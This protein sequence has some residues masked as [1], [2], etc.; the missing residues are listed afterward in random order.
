MKLKKGDW[1][2]GTSKATYAYTNSYSV[3]EI[4]EIRT[5]EYLLV[6]CLYSLKC[7]INKE[8]QLN[9]LSVESKYFRKLTA[10]EIKKYY[11]LIVAQQI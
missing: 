4:I 5:N 10:K 11:P 3:N 2:T 7:D 6:R 9:K 1:I 8:F